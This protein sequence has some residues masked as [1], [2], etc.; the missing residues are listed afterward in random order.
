[1]SAA[2]EFPPST[3]SGTTVS[4][5]VTQVDRGISNNLMVKEISDLVE[6]ISVNPPVSNNFNPNIMVTPDSE[7]LASHN[8]QKSFENVLQEIEKSLTKFDKEDIS[9]KG[10][11]TLNS[12]IS[13][14]LENNTIII[15][16]DY[17]NIPAMHIPLVSKAEILAE[18]VKSSDVDNSSNL[19]IKETL[20]LRL[21]VYNGMI[22]REWR[23]ME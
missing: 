6:H 12:S 22:I 18:L 19:E 2:K 13:S 4:G 20:R 17:S 11:S 3:T 10:G 21:G 7:I 14:L 15:G 8:S 23:G 1:M 16:E 5:G 9:N